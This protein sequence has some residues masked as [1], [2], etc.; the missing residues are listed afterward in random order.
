[1]YKVSLYV[2]E[3]FLN[4]LENSNVVLNKLAQT[5][6]SLAIQEAIRENDKQIQILKLRYRFN[7]N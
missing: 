7:D 5:D 4:S 1:M 3:G 2:L 6:D